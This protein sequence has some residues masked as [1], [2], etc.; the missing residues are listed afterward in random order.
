MPG[1][2]KCLELVSLARDRWSKV[3]LLVTSGDHFV[4]EAALP[5]AGTFVHKPWSE[6]VLIAK[7]TSM[8]A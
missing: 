2:M 7:I 4:A 5:D 8:L 3:R 1:R 6:E